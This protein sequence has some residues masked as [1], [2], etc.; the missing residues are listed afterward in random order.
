[1]RNAVAFAD[2]SA[3]D[4]DSDAIGYGNAECD[5]ECNTQRDTEYNAQRDANAV[6]YAASYSQAATNPAPASDAWL[7]VGPQG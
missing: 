3:S 1:M 2:S 4:T 5:A 6:S 7:S